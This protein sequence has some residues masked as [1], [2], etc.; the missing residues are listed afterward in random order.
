MHASGAFPLGCTAR[1]GPSTLAPCVAG[2][3]TRRPFCQSWKISPCACPT[4]RGRGEIFNAARTSAGTARGA[5]RARSGPPLRKSRR[6][7]ADRIRRTLRTRTRTASRLD[8]LEASLHAVGCKL[9]ALVF[10]GRD[11]PERLAAVRAR[12]DLD[13][14]FR[15]DDGPAR[16]Y[17]Q[18][19]LGRDLVI[20]APEHQVD[21][22]L[23]QFSKGRLDY[24]KESVHGI[25]GAPVV[26]AE[27]RGADQCQNC[28]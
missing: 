7:R 16:L 25:G 3:G 23:C 15:Q 11:Y 26:H 12:H 8:L 19:D 24:P 20:P 17:F 6:R 22:A 13:G 14:L 1:A 18:D 4:R 27:N 10:V 2:Y 28:G 21:V 9:A 5:G